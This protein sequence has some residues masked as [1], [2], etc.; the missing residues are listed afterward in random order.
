MYSAPAFYEVAI[1][2]NFLL[3]QPPSPYHL[4]YLY[5][6]E[7]VKAQKVWTT[8][9]HYLPAVYNFLTATQVLKVFLIEAGMIRVCSM[10]QVDLGAKLLRT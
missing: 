1:M 10:S 9:S 2:M 5:S 3:F 6:E 7:Q 4:Q 8:S